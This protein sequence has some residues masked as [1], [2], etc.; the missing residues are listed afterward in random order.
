MVHAAHVSDGTGGNISDENSPL[1]TGLPLNRVWVDDGVVVGN[2]PGGLLSMKGW[3][4]VVASSRPRRSRAGWYWRGGGECVARRE[5]NGDT[6][7]DHVL[8]RGKSKEVHAVVRFRGSGRNR[9]MLKE[10]LNPAFD[11]PAD[12]GGQG[13]VLVDEP[14]ELGLEAAGGQKC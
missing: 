12:L 8:E 11:E 4:R 14:A 10:L 9:A 3:R 6:V 7:F 5:A 13:A 1:V 2:G